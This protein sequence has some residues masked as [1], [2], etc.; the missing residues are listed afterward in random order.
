M[1]TICEGS[2]LLV[3]S[4]CFF[5]TQIYNK[6]QSV[7]NSIYK[8]IQ[9]GSKNLQYYQ[10]NSRMV[11]RHIH[12]VVQQVYINPGNY[13]HTKEKKSAKTSSA[14]GSN[15]HFSF[16]P[17]MKN[18]PKGVFLTKDE[19]L[20]WNNNFAIPE[21][22]SCDIEC[23]VST[24][25]THK[26]LVCINKQTVPVNNN[27]I[28]ISRWID[29]QTA[30]FPKR[31]VHDSTRT[32]ALKSVLELS[33]QLQITP[34]LS[35][36]Y[37]CEMMTCLNPNDVISNQDNVQDDLIERYDEDT[38]VKSRKKK[39]KRQILDDSSEDE[40]F[41]IH[42][43]KRLKSDDY[44]DCSLEQ[45]VKETNLEKV[46]P[47]SPPLEDSDHTPYNDDGGGDYVPHGNSDDTSHDDNDRTPPL[48]QGVVPMPPNLS[49]I[50]WLDDVTSSQFLSQTPCM[51]TENRSHQSLVGGS[52]LQK[53]FSEFKKPKK[54]LST[55]KKPKSFKKIHHPSSL[56]NLSMTP[57]PAL[58]LNQSIVSSPKLSSS[59]PVREGVSTNDD[60]SISLLNDLP[61]EALF[62]DCQVSVTIEPSVIPES[63][64]RG[65]VKR[66]QPLTNHNTIQLYNNNDNRLLPNV[67]QRS[68]DKRSPIT[69]DI[70]CLKD[71]IAANC[72]TK[73]P[74][75]KINTSPNNISP[76]FKS[77]KLFLEKVVV[78]KSSPNISHSTPSSSYMFPT[79]DSEEKYLKNVRT[80]KKI[81]QPFKQP[82]FLCSQVPSSCHPN[83]PIKKK[84]TKQWN[85]KTADAN[86]VD[87]DFV[88]QP[89][90]RRVLFTP[91]SPASDSNESDSSRME[92]NKG[93]LIDEEAMLSGDSGSTNE[94]EDLLTC[95]EYDYDDSFIND[96]SVLT[97][98][99]TA[100]ELNKQ[101]TDNIP[102]N[103]YLRSLR[104]PGNMFSR[105]NNANG[106]KYRLVYSQRYE[107]LNKYV[108][109]AGLKVSPS[110]RNSRN[111][112]TIFESE[113]SEAEE[114]TKVNDDP[115]ITSQEYNS[116]FED[117]N[118]EIINENDYR[119]E[120][121]SEADTDDTHS[122]E[123]SQQ[124]LYD[125]EHTMTQI[126][127]KTKLTSHE[128]DVE[129]I[130]LSS[131][132]DDDG[133]ASQYVNKLK[134]KGI[135]M[136]IAELISQGVIVSPSLVVS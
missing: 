103:M 112:N 135:R 127:G 93:S 14:K 106:N 98:H 107:L 115:E 16:G 65:S 51:Q 61:S 85:N 78:T 6:S 101:S 31:F 92:D 118:E 125:H 114:V 68:P 12:P 57:V 50:A 74:A 88:V 126:F 105:K 35:S 73:P 113:E 82:D 41:K 116:M 34:E 33:D 28:S 131:S 83:D 53:E 30:P 76:T 67:R 91:P 18:D 90:K 13:Q 132:S 58:K 29:W 24:C 123:D 69:P 39:L 22:Q 36:A 27:T 1:H 72:I 66:N 134:D 89:R 3:L 94:Q 46:M 62:G 97:Q 42:Q 87:E 121:Q 7:K 133:D 59:T 9:R 136:T 23:A 48:S 10:F 52:L 110:A 117:E 26:P 4:F 71:R 55:M 104:S 86:T 75:M 38:G 20:Y 43:K 81:R 99:V 5:N 49:T 70:P 79:P 95:H 100:I 11:P 64:V 19:L 45:I 84:H 47:F 122:L 130:V 63:P 25:V 128:H 2:A 80:S 108:E 37:D 60:Y 129:P 32:N 119:T 109:K 15:N 77:S 40:D 124:I 120:V 102:D 96:N 56:E 54:P 44:D 17:N 21:D 8:A 111:N